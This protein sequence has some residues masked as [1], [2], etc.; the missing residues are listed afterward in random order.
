MATALTRLREKAAETPKGDW[1]MGVL[2]DNTAIAER[3]M[4]TR[5]ELDSVSTEHPVWVIHA[6]GHNG[7]ANSFA[8]QKQGVD[9]GTPEPPGGRFGRDPD[10]GALTGLIEGI[11]AMVEM[12]DTDFLIDRNRFWQG[13]NACR[14]EYLAHGVTFAQNAWATRTMLDHFASLPAGHDPGIDI[15]LL[16]MAALEPALLNGPGA[17]IWPDTPYFTLG[18]R[19][20][21]TDGAFPTADRVSQR[22]LSPPVRS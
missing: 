5:E 15:L 13:F 11:S 19:K 22:T 6:S 8:L 1:V 10:S 3:R 17:L 12:G 9:R 2:F 16:P 21:F 14:D 7:T 20:L 18:P 4:P